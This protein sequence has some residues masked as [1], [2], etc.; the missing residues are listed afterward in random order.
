MI[1]RNADGSFP[2]NLKICRKS[3]DITASDDST[4]GNEWVNNRQNP[5]Q[6]RP[7]SKVNPVQ[8]GQMAKFVYNYNSYGL[9]S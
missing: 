5:D 7:T 9:W 6:S 1:R 3:K 2:D 4:G 8:C